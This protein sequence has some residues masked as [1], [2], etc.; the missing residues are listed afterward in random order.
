MS[1]DKTRNL[2]L[3][4]YLEALQK[5]Y[6]NAELRKKVYPITK[7]KEFYKRTMLHKEEKINDIA[8]RNGLPTIFVDQSE[9]ERLYALIYGE[10]GLPKFIYRNEGDI[11]EFRKWDVINYFAEGS[12]VKVITDEEIKVGI[13]SNN[14]EVRN[15]FFKENGI[16]DDTKH[17]V[18]V[19][20]RG[21]HQSEVVLIK[22]ISRIL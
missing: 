20:F 19:K 18:S 21:E 11:E 1:K 4:D 2:S 16:V 7:D 9:H 17:V 13:I 22:N 14:Q 3:Y 15:I 6:I 10:S 5:E 12:E 8:K